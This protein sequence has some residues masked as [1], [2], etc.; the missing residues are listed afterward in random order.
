MWVKIEVKSDHS[1]CSVTYPVSLEKQLAAYPDVVLSDLYV[2]ALIEE[3]EKKDAQLYRRSG[4]CAVPL[5][6]LS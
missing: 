6:K 3:V 4:I 1:G 5:D 2:K